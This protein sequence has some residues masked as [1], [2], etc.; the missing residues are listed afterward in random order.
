MAAPTRAQISADVTRPTY[1]TELFLTGSWTDVSADVDTMR[2]S[3][4]ATGDASG[5][6]FGVVV[7]PSADVDFNI[8]GLARSWELTP[9]R[10]SYGFSTSDLIPRFSGVITGRRRTPFG[11]TW[12][13]R[14][15]D[16]LIEGKVVRSP[17]F[18]RRPIATATTLTSIEDPTNPAY[19]A[20]IVNYI[21]WQCG[22]RPYEQAASYTSALWYYSCT[23]AL[24]APEWTWI[25]GENPWQALQRFVRAAGGQLYQ[26][27]A[28]VL[29]Y[30][31][32]LTFANGTAAH[33]YTDAAQSAA[34]RVTNDTAGYSDLSASDDLTDS[35]TGMTCA[36]VTRL[37]QG[38]QQVY[39]DTQPRPITEAGGEKDTLTHHCD[40]TLPIFSIDRVERD[41]AVQRTA[42]APSTSEVTIGVTSSS[43]QRITV[44]VTNELGEPVQVDNIRVFGRPVSAGEEGTAEYIPGGGPLNEER[45]RPVEDNP[46]IQSA[47]HARQICRMAYDFASQAGSVI[48]LYDV[49][50]DPDRYV[51]ELVGLTNSAWNLTAEPHRIVALR[52]EDGSFMEVDL[53]PLNGLPTRADVF[54]VGTSYAGGDQRELSY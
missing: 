49:A 26:D 23:H 22:G 39:E 11:G 13:C 14:G 47:R 43:S 6:A 44:Q 8:D 48:T 24:I 30:I 37:V 51:G 53:A 4:E 12:Q 33:T 46:W 35:V 34:Q 17:L 21:L 36:F 10:I 28:G 7:T 52:P 9:I 38:V 3:V 15:W 19:A 40:T 31:D 1:K 41:C 54:I 45:T 16:A 32:P 25:S 50:Y 42:Y 29:R 2:H 27:D 18:K 20:G 5:M